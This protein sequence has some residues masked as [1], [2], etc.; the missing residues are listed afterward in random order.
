MWAVPIHTDN[1]YSFAQAKPVYA[2]WDSQRGT[3]NVPGINTPAIPSEGDSTLS[4]GTTDNRFSLPNSL[5]GDDQP[6]P[7]IEQGSEDFPVL[8]SESQLASI[9][10]LLTKIFFFLIMLKS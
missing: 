7:L 3:W 4:P 8:H 10:I 5:M 2:H 1:T 9:L 6:A